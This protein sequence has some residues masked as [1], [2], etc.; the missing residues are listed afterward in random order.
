MGGR[1]MR[2]LELISPIIGFAL[3][4]SVIIICILY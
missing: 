2:T 1:V 3:A 4:V